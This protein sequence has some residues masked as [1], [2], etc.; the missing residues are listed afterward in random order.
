MVLVNISDLP[1]W[2]KLHP[3]EKS[4]YVKHSDAVALFTFDSL[5][6]GF[7][8]PRFG[9]YTANG[10]FVFY[11]SEGT[12]HRVFNHSRSKMMIG[13]Q[14]VWYNPA[15]TFDKEDN[16]EWIS[17]DDDLPA[18]MWQYEEAIWNSHV[19]SPC[20]VIT[21]DEIIESAVWYNGWLVMHNAAGISGTHN[22][23][24]GWFRIDHIDE[25]GCM[26]LGKELD[27]VKW[28]FKVNNGNCFDRYPKIKMSE[29]LKV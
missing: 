18:P 3:N 23:K 27:V 8:F 26:D 5:Q 29:A 17:V 6:P 15:N 1:E 11:D 21:K 13:T 16:I 12:C 4:V 22:E 19:S 24:K 20:K 14:P 25:D 9:Q 7:A 2:R 10:D 28:H